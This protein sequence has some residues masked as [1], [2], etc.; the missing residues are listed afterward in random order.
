MKAKSAFPRMCMWVELSNSA[1]AKFIN[2]I[3]DPVRERERIRVAPQCEEESE[4]KYVLHGSRSLFTVSC[5]CSGGRWGDGPCH[6]TRCVS[7]PV[8]VLLYSNV[9]LGWGVCEQLSRLPVT[10][11]LPP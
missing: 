7:V 10:P 2:L 8:C 5:V 9:A 1:G 11:S 4:M 6:Q 3:L